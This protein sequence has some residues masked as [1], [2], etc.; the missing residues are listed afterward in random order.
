MIGLNLHRRAF[1]AL[2]A[3]TL[4]ARCPQYEA[5]V[6]HYHSDSPWFRST[7]IVLRKGRLWAGGTT[8]LEPIGQGLFRVSGESFSPDVVE[9]LQVANGKALQLKANGSDQWRVEIP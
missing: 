9:F 4:I 1:L 7:R 3:S 8:P 6:G 2:G 5:F